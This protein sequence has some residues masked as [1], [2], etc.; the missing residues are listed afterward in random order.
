MAS[1]NIGL[2]F[3][4][5]GPFADP[6]LFAH[7][8]QTAERCGFESI[9]TVEHVVIP[10]DYK[11]PYPYSRSGKIPGPEDVAIPDPLLPLAFAAAITKNLKLGTGVLIL[12]QRH[13]LYVAKE[14]ATLDLLSNGRL[15]LG[16]GSG[17]LEEEFQALG[18]DFHQRG[19]R[20]DEAIQSLRA[21]W[22]DGASM[23]HGKHFN[24]GPVQCFPKP[25]RKT[26]V[27]IIIG[28]HSPAAARRAGRYGDGF[29]PAIGEPPKL[30]ELFA[31]M[32]AEAK[33]AGRNAA[34]I[35]LS[36]M[37]RAKLD[38]IKAVQDVGVTRV[39]VAPPGHDKDGITRGLET[40][41]NE[42]IAKL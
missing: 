24:F 26:G 4:N 6:Q 1:M 17:W 10:K 15:L 37:G 13:P 29:F 23:F 2:M 33:K 16:I 12:P 30:K 34:A 40:L 3:A 38:A 31:M 39:V 32:T 27:P 35:E 19:R 22:S 18:L 8:A 36:C 11:S 5:S 41:A 20:T 21:L 7:L 42:V 28:G 9:W 25:V 14:T